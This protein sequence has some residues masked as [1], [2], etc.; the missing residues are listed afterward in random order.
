VY[1]ASWFFDAARDEFDDRDTVHRDTHRCLAQSVVQG[2]VDHDAA[3][4]AP[5]APEAVD[6]LIAEPDWLVRL[7]DKVADGYGAHGEE[8]AAVLFRAIGY[9]L[10]SEVLADQ[11]FSLID[12]ELRAAEPELVAWLESHD[13]TIAGQPHNAY[14]WIRIHSGHGGGAEADHFD[15]ALQGVSR[16]FRYARDDLRGTARAEILAGFDGFAEDHA[17][18]FSAVNR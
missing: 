3:H 1:V 11:E 2:L 15:W 13:V 14:T 5:W 17:T 10:G 12:A 4:G 9:H 8:S 6:A 7:M 16:A 18:F